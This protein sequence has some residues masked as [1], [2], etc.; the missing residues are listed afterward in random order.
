MA[1]VNA[2]GRDGKTTNPQIQLITGSA[3][4]VIQ[5]VL[6]QRDARGEDGADNLIIGFRVYKVNGSIYRTRSSVHE[7]SV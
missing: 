5:V 4:Q 1:G 6:A 7:G 2:G 3:G